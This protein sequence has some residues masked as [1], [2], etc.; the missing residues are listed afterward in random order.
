MSIRNNFSRFICIVTTIPL[1]FTVG[2][3]P[4]GAKAAPYDASLA[5]KILQWATQQRVYLSAEEQF[6]LDETGDGTVNAV[7]ALQVLQIGVN[8]RT[9]TPAVSIEH[10]ILFHQEYAPFQYRGLDSTAGIYSRIISPE[11]KFWWAEHLGLVGWGHPAKEEIATVLDEECFKT[12]T[13]V[14]LQ[15]GGWHQQ[16]FQVTGVLS[17]GK[18]LLIQGEWQ[19]A[20]DR[21]TNWQLLLVKIPKGQYSR[22]FVYT[23]KAEQL[24]HP[25]VVE[26]REAIDVDADNFFAVK[27]ETDG[28]VIRNPEEFKALFSDFSLWYGPNPNSVLKHQ[29]LWQSIV[30]PAIEHRLTDEF[31]QNY[32]TVVTTR[33]GSAISP[34]QS[35]A[36][37]QE[38]NI[39]LCLAEILPDDID[40]PG[41]MGGIRRTRMGFIDIPITE[42]MPET[43]SIHSIP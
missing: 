42:N 43:V 3:L 41:V 26:I 27:L 20:K 4:V 5:L 24:T 17:K 2:C 1:L 10:Q 22:A 29:Q 39:P 12:S 13:A 37:D 25:Q 19:E 16:T 34:F 40:P 30:L 8:K 21:P 38:G 11:E 36:I 23:E 18:S 14:A 31:Y 6:Q 15:I 35:A 33:M 9:P 28:V 7:D 32:V